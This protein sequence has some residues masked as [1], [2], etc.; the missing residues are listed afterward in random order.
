MSM[1]AWNTA[2]IRCAKTRCKWRGYEG[3]LSSIPHPKFA[4]ARQSVCPACGCDSYMHMTE[5]EI[6][7]WKPPIETAKEAL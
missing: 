1:P 3:E 6:A 4:G 5:R 7:A 2:P